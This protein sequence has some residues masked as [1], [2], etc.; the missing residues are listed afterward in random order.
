MRAAAEWQRASSPPTRVVVSGCG[1]VTRLFAAPAL[2]SLQSRG[3]VEVVGAF[4]P[5]QAAMNAVRAILPG[6]T[7]TAGFDALVGLGAGLAIA[8]SPPRLH[9][10]QSIAAMR[11]GLDVLCEK[12]MAITVADADRMLAVAEETG[13]IF[14]AGHVRRHLPATQAAKALIEAGALGRLKSIEWFEG[15][16]FVWPVASPSYFTIEQSGG[17][18]LPDIGTHVFDLLRW[19]LGPPRLLDYA[20]DA[21]GGVEANCLVRLDL[22][23]CEA[24]VRLSRDWTRPN[25][26]RSGVKSRIPARIVS[27]PEVLELT[28]HGTGGLAATIDL[29]RPGKAP[30]DF[31]DCYAAEIADVAAAGRAGRSPAVPGSAPRRARARRSVPVRGPAD[32]HAMVGIQSGRCR[33]NAREAGRM[34]AVVAVLG[35]AG[36]IGNRTVEMLHLG[37]SHQVRPVVRRA[38]SLALPRRFAVSAAIADATDEAALANAFAGCTHV[39]HAVAGDPA[40]TV[41][42]IEP[43]YRAAATAKVRRL[44]YISSASVHGQSPRPGRAKTARSTTDRGSPTTTLRSRPSICSSGCAAM[45]GLRW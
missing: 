33:R 12:P 19:W 26:V 42:S 25:R 35:A 32:E 3:E 39:V 22:G 27:H 17:G 18:V 10:D 24:R 4:D 31:V 36:F 41:G 9:A 23:S 37:G 38:S 30:L 5:K 44:V 21:M 40:T 2:A 16:P 13:R 7:A 1:A 20:D 29:R 34:S 11:A 43:T 8:A 15:G 14:A 28:L 45:V 6:A